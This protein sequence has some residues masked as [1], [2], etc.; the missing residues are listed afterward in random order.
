LQPRAVL[1]TNADGAGIVQAVGPLKTLA[2]RSSQTAEDSRKFLVIT[3]M[4]APERVVL[5]QGGS[6]KL[7]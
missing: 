4:N 5:R 1:K 6:E 7:E 2:S 3:E